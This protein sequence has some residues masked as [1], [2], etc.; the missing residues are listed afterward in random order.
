MCTLY[1]E[2]CNLFIMRNQFSSLKSLGGHLQ[3]IVGQKH[4]RVGY[5]IFAPNFSSRTE[6]LVHFSFGWATFDFGWKF[7]DVWPFFKACTLFIPEYINQSEKRLRKVEHYGGEMSDD[8]L[9]Y[10]LLKNVNLKQRKE[11]LIKV[12]INVFCYNLIKEQLK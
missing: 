10:H 1:F 7:S 3:F 12:S 4:N 5:V 2:Y 11:Q 9:A 6:C 8:I